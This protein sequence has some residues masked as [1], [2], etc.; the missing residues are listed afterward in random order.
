MVFKLGAQFFSRISHEIWRENLAAVHA[1]LLVSR[2]MNIRYEYDVVDR[3][4]VHMPIAISYRDKVGQGSKTMKEAEC[5][6]NLHGNL[7]HHMELRSSMMSL[8]TMLVVTSC[9]SK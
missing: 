8:Q 9:S 3:F 4:H 7:C 5:A 1:T 6:E 2:Q